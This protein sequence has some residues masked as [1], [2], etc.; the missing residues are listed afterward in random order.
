MTSHTVTA[1]GVVFLLTLISNVYAASTW[2]LQLLSSN[3]PPTFS[4]IAS[5]HARNGCLPDLAPANLPPRLTTLA[6][7]LSLTSTT[8]LQTCS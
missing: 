1:V 3:R 8:L 4:I 6:I 7:S 2:H 5:A